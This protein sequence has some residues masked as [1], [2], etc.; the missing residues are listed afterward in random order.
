MSESLPLALVPSRDSAQ[1]AWREAGRGCGRTRLLCACFTRDGAPLTEGRTR[2]VS[3]VSS[4]SGHHADNGEGRRVRD[5]PLTRPKRGSTLQDPKAVMTFMVI[6]SERKSKKQTA[7]S[8]IQTRFSYT[9][10]C[11]SLGRIRKGSLEKLY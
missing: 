2:N 7:P 11:I 10:Y 3:L 9:S 6:R 8:Y 4:A 5:G 1:R